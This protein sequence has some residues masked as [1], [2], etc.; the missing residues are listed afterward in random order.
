M[1]KTMKTRN[2]IAKASIRM[3]NKVVQDKRRKLLDQAQADQPESPLADL[4]PRNPL[5]ASAWAGSFHYALTRKDVMAAFREET[6]NQW[7]PGRTPIDQMFDSA[8]GADLAFIRAFA[9]WH[10]E[11]IWGEQD[12]KP[13]DVGN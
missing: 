2:P 3:P 9:K 12:G 11:W 7:Q 13:M 4:M 1:E 10:N 6:G 8:A 5:M